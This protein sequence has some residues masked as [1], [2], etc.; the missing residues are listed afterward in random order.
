MKADIETL[1][2]KVFEVHD[3]EEC[4]AAADVPDARKAIKRARKAA[5]PEYLKMLAAISYD[6]V[7]LWS[8]S[9]MLL[10]LDLDKAN[11]KGAWADTKALGIARAKKGT[12][13]VFLDAAGELGLRGA[14]YVTAARGPLVLGTLRVQRVADDTPALLGLLASETAPAVFRA[15]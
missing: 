5:T 8:G 12:G 4:D 7:P 6:D 11:V 10:G 13:S 3:I 15:G 9:W 2:R 14:Y 1:V